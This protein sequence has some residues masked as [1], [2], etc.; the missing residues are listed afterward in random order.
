MGP[1]NTWIPDSKGARQIKADQ[2][3][4]REEAM[5]TISNPKNRRRKGGK[6]NA[7]KTKAPPA[8]APDPEYEEDEFEFMYLDAVRSLGKGLSYVSFTNL[9]PCLE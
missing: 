6:H 7:N 8:A 9:V 4:K 5:A 3:K 2:K 1:G